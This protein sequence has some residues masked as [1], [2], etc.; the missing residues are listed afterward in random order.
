MVKHIAMPR[1]PVVVALIAVL[2]AALAAS[3]CGVK[4]PLVPAP[5][6][7]AATPPQASPSANDAPPAERKP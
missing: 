7:A 6:P 4:G 5:R 2:G 1:R 3:G